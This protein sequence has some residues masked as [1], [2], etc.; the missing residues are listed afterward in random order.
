M[1]IGKLKKEL[2]AKTDLM[3]TVVKENNF[4][5]NQLGDTKRRCG[6]LK[7]QALKLLAT[8]EFDRKRIA[9]LQAQLQHFQT[10]SQAPKVED[11]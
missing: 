2:R 8:Q 1:D 10:L 5:G 4:L 3:Q 9:S 7:N 6:D 11:V